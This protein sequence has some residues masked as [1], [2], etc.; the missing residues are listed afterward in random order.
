MNRIRAGIGAFILAAGTYTAFDAVTHG[1]FLWVF[2]GGIA[3][4]FGGSVLVGTL[5]LH[6]RDAPD[7]FDL[8]S[9]VDAGKDA[10]EDAGDEE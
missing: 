3:M 1:D 4:M 5:I 2:A 7:P 10:A 8:D 6:H 9:A